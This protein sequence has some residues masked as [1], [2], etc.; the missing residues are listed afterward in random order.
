MSNIFPINM[1]NVILNKIN[2][3]GIFYPVEICVKKYNK[4]GI[5]DKIKNE[6]LTKIR[7][8]N[9]EVLLS[10]LNDINKIKN[11]IL[12]S[13]NINNS[14]ETLMEDT[15]KNKV[16]FKNFEGD[17]LSDLPFFNSSNDLKNK[18]YSVFFKHYIEDYFSAIPKSIGHFFAYSFFNSI[19]NIKSNFN[20]SRLINSSIQ[21]GKFVK[22][23]LYC[24]ET[25]KDFI[26]NK[27]CSPI[28]NS[29]FLDF[30]KKNKVMTFI[31]NNMMD[32]LNNPESNSCFYDINQYPLKNFKFN[33]CIS[34]INEM[35][36]SFKMNRIYWLPLNSMN[37][38]NSTKCLSKKIFDEAKKSINICDEND[39]LPSEIV[40]DN[41]PLSNISHKNTE[42]HFK[43]LVPDVFLR[44]LVKVCFKKNLTDLP[45]LEIFYN[46]KEMSKFN[47]EKSIISYVIKN[48][49]NNKLKLIVTYL[50]KLT[51]IEKENVT[52][53]YTHFG[54]RTSVILSTNELPKIAYFNF[55]K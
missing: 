39:F 42:I 32:F 2:Q 27:I 5:L 6:K 1:K 41:Y 30:F 48:L 17:I 52:I 33:N 9:N 55:I 12:N 53:N 54:A 46:T 45:C 21:T 29:S 47:P 19:H 31:K 14:V 15:L 37:Q 25:I 26:E 18:N 7:Q 10:Q 44:N 16:S 49:K 34:D 38:L 28:L 23:I 4:S 36:E 8:N 40:I 50:G 13:Y 22:N 35:N 20:G 24:N 43:K 11:K 3:D 51:R